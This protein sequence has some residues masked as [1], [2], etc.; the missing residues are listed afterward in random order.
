MYR[1]CKTCGE[2]KILE[3]DFYV[4]NRGPNGN[5]LFYRHDCKSCH[6]KRTK[7]VRGEQRQ[8][9]FELKKTWTCERC[10]FDDWRAIQLH[11]HNDDKEFGVSDAIGRYSWNKIV[12]EINKCEKVCANC[13]QILH[14]KERELI[15]V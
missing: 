2:T 1:K 9:Y 6:Y 4:S 13:H 11:H 14:H 7:S 12:E 5:A 10:G 8:K 15:N 3:E